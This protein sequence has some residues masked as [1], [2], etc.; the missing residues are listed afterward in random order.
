MSGRPG[1]GSPSA[2]ALSHVVRNGAD[3]AAE[4]GA[5]PTKVHDELARVNA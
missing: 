2:A 5:A 4:F 1:S 3:P